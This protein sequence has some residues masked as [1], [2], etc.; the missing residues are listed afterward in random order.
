MPQSLAAC[1]AHVVFSTKNRA[2]FLADASLRADTHAYLGGIARTLE[3][4]PL[5]VGGVEDHVHL[6]VG[7]ARTVCVADLVKELKRNSTDWMRGKGNKEFY[8]Q[9]GYG[10]FSVSKSNLEMVTRY[11]D[12]Q[13]EHH[14]GKKVSF[15]D[16]Y[17]EMLRKHAVAWDEQFVWD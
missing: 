5:C 10:V 2:P 16:E 6:L 1:F 13:E 14:H 11:I 15:Q 7:Q 12:N 8:W 3:C 4:M 9:A 17:R